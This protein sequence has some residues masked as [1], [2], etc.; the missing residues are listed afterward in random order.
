MTASTQR[1]PLSAALYLLALAA[2]AVLPADLSCRLTHFCAERADEAL[3]HLKGKPQS[4]PSAL[5]QACNPKSKNGWEVSAC[6]CPQDAS[7]KM[8]G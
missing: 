4:T 8:L 1:L 2:G 6:P 3:K 7:Q 5:A